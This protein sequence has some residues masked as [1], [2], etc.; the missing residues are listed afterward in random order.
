MVLYERRSMGFELCIGPSW[1]VSVE[2]DQG[3]SLNDSKEF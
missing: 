1:C 2:R 3:P